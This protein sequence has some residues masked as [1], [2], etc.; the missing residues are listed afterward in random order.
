MGEPVLKLLLVDD[1]DSV[2]E[3]LASSLQT[4]PYY[5]EVTDVPDF[6]EAVRSLEEKSGNFDV[7]LIDEVLGEGPSG[8]EILKYIKAT[9]SDIEVILFTGWGL[10]SGEE[11]RQI[12]AYSYVAKPFNT[13]ELAMTIYNAAERNRI[14]REHRYMEALVKASRALAQ[15]TQTDNQLNLA[16]DFVREQLAVSSFFIALYSSS[17]DRVYFPLAFDESRQVSL[18]DV[19]I[20]RDSSTWGLAGYVVK[21]G[22]E[23]L[24]STLSEKDQVCDQKKIFPLRDGEPS[25]SCFCIP[26]ILSNHVRGVLS[27][28]SYQE[29][30]FA[31]SLQNA[32]RALAGHLSVALDNSRLFSELEQ[33]AKDNENQAKRIAALEN[34]AVNINSNLEWDE[35]LTRTSQEA[36]D[37]FHA[38]HSGLV[39]FDQNYS[40]GIVEAEYP[41]LG[42]RGRQVP[43]RGIPLE[44]QFVTNPKPLVIYD[45]PKEEGLGSVKDI[46]LSLGICSSLFVPVVGKTGLLGSFSLDSIQQKRHFTEEDIQLCQIFASQVAIAIENA[47]LYGEAREGREYLHSLFKASSEVVSPH[48]PNDVLQGIVTQ[49]H[50]STGAWRTV[51]LLV[52]A[53]GYPQVLASSGFDLQLEAATSIRERGISHQVMDS[54]EPRFFE[55]AEAEAQSVHPAMLEQ[56]VKAAACLPLQLMGKNIGALWIHYREKHI[57]S[58]SEKQ[59]LQIYVNQSAVA[60]ENARH[61]RELEQLREA[62][63]SMARV[64]EPKQVLQKIVDGAKRVLGADSALIWSYDS[65]RDIFIPEELVAKGILEE[66]LEKFRR[67]E[68]KAGRTTRLVLEKGYLKVTD[69]STSP[70]IGSP[71]R[72]FLKNLGVESFQSIRLDVAGE[73]LGVLHV[74][75]KT[76]RDFG[77]EERRILEHFANHAALTLKKARL[78]KQVKRAREA[79]RVVTEV[80]ALGKLGGTLKAIVRGA[81]DAL[82]CDIVTLYTFDEKAQ[83]FVGV[84]GTGLKNRS[85]LRSPQEVA[86]DSSLW[87]VVELDKPFYHFAENAP[88]DRLLQ[89]GFVRNEKVRSA[90]G[91]QLRFGE[92][93]VGVMFVN[94]RAPHRFIQD[95]IND[96]LQFGN[97]AVVAIRNAQLHESTGK[98]AETL[99]SLYKAGK[100]VT[101]LLTLDE[102]LNRIAAQAWHLT[103]R[104][105]SYTSIRLV[106]GEIAKVVAAYPREE[107][108]QTLATVP[109]INL[110][111]GINGRFGVTGQAVRKG[112]PQLVHDVSINDDYLPSHPQ[113]RSELALPIKL[114]R[115]TIGVIN[116]ESSELQNFDGDDE[117]ALMSLASYAAIAINNARLHGKAKEQAK[118]LGGLYDAGKAITNT[119]EVDQVLTNI[120]EQALRIVGADVQEGCFSHVALLDGNKL[121]FIAGFP[122]EILDDLRKNIGEIDLRKDK[123]KGIAGHVVLT[124]LPQKVDETVGNPNYIALRENINIHSQLSVPLKVGGRVIGVL[125]IEH[126]TPNN[127]NS[128]DVMNIEMLA[129]QASI[130]LENARRVAQIKSMRAAAEDMAR[131]TT[132]Q[133][134]LNQIVA[135]AR[136]VMSADAA[137]IWE[138]DNFRDSFVP[139]RLVFS[140]I[141]EG[142]RDGNQWQIP[143]QGGIAYTILKHGTVIVGDIMS[144]NIPYLRDESRKS[145]VEAGVR[146]FIGA[147]LKVG[148]EKLGVLYVDYYQ[149]RALGDDDNQTIKNF[150]NLAAL[151]LKNAKFLEQQSR[152]RTASRVV[153]ELTVLGDLKKTLESIVAGAKEALQCD[154]VTLYTYNQETDEFGF[155]PAME[156]VDDQ[157]KALM[158][159]GVT[160]HSVVQKILAL[161]K[162]YEAEDASSDLV[163]QGPFVFREKIR[164]SVGIPLK[165]GDRKVGVMF[166]NYRSPHRFTADESTNIELFANQAAVAV[167]NAQLHN[168]IQKRADNLDAVIRVSQTVI[169]SLDLDHILTTAC[170]AAVELLGVD[171]SGLV[172]FDE[173]QIE[174][175]VCAE[176]PELGALGATFPLRGVPAEEQLIKSKQPIIIPDVANE[177]GFESVR[178]IHQNLGTRSMLIVPVISKG[179]ILGSFGLDNL[180]K[181]SIITSEEIELC[182]VFAAQVAVAIENSRQY[183][184]LKRTKGLVGA[185][186]ALAWTGMISSTWRHTIEKHAITIREQIELLRGDLAKLPKNDSI[187]KRLEM[188]ERL[189]NQILKKP[190]SAPL[191]AEEEATSVSVNEFIKERVHQ[192]WAHQPYKEVGIELHLDLENFTTVRASIEWLRRAVDILVDNAVDATAG[193]D[194]RKI[195]ISTRRTDRRAE[196]LIRDNGRGITPEVQESLF[197]EPIEKHKDAK[198]LGMGLLFAQMILQT[199]GGEI[200]LGETGA[201]G[202]TMIILLPLET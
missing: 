97:Q 113:T 148:E 13:D 14:R 43:I 136:N 72:E 143:Q 23:V 106:D 162:A 195:V 57:F 69:V 82:D 186:T 176:Y 39:I 135:S 65:N 68:P 131:V 198:G 67:E 171:H 119:L 122:S 19:I 75:Y 192:L 61:I 163:M 60:Y 58:E 46:M 88:D 12:G 42:A 138:Y 188:M 79:A 115:R 137:A 71:T 107:L 30:V 25:A 29:H 63:E 92:E 142:L 102:I 183:D 178:T 70:E 156:G 74:D 141:S 54:G 38:D 158:L 86:H 62:T 170:Q 128:E 112:L 166:V 53:G 202:T 132:V 184:E 177:L 22:E 11:V 152:A 2:R 201:E 193:I 105:A 56:G 26:L 73:P 84:E 154:V 165:V 9:Y 55:D 200:K 164:S 90:L 77:K 47:H 17:E 145:L 27:A 157:T 41:S 146:S 8:L 190:L 182:K 83:R 130:A 149:L 103:K 153:A 6:E 37:F 194:K 59:A 125:S 16:W 197:R 121:R 104:P 139:N 181:E 96:A 99:E 101:G 3:P 127:F 167:R 18:P 49:A 31:P 134:V 175:R 129:A 7:A 51:I 174:G 35:I 80:T 98:Q 94:Y 87:R 24:W 100:A 199:Y 40:Q 160:K 44:E 159:N 147:A 189:A 126:P 196:I 78:L 116:V 169:S 95:E 21:K 172:L 45:L 10:K 91:V 179:K 52:D 50:H 32:L 36:V 33:R 85:N 118:T 76:I 161:E 173:D 109:E 110:K 108:N 28:Q 15:T 64:E 120:A 89:G 133:E 187:E 111:I 114:G 144:E 191:S 168:E 93:R 155:P 124:R 151:A 185:R 180:K 5:Y 20:G 117:H 123:L 4:K 150:V 81:K 66:Q 34:L 140:G 48:D 1:E